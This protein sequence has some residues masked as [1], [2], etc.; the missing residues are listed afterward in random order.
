MPFT[1]IYMM[2]NQFSLI[3]D[4]FKWIKMVCFSNSLGYLNFFLFRTLSSID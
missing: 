1:V 2:K 4:N 3:G